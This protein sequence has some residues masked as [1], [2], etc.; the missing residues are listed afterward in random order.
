MKDLL[1]APVLDIAALT[2]RFNASVDRQEAA[3]AP[4]T[5]QIGDVIQFYHRPYQHCATIRVTKV[6]RAT[7]KGVEIERSYKA[8]A[9][10][11]VHKQGEGIRMDQKVG[12]EEVR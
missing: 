1:D 5:L 7:F 11:T 9:E 8:G 12:Q 4:A 10:W 2:R 3:Y 6:N